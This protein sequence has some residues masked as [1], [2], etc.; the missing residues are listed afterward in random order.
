MNLEETETFVKNAHKGQ[1]R[2][3][4]NTPY[5]EHPLR[6]SNAMKKFG[7][8]D[9]QKA[10][11]L[12]DVLED[13]KIKEEELNNHYNKKIIRIVKELTKDKE[14]PKE[15][16]QEKYSKQ[17]KNASDEAKLIKL[18][19][20]KDNLEEKFEPGWKE[21]LKKTKKQLNALSLKNNHNKEYFENT[22]KELLKKINQ[23]LK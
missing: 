21:F 15:L 22:K 10:A 5:Y 4:S 3:S 7:D 9:L 18:H 14:L 6:V 17:L 13:T 2:K 12:H 8:P 20:I 16:S 1:L 19:D 23:E 11:L